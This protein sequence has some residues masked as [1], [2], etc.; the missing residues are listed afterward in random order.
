AHLQNAIIFAGTMRLFAQTCEAVAATTKKK[1]KV[2][3]VAEYIRTAP[4]EEAAC[5]AVFLTGFAFPRNRNSN[6]SVGGSLLWD[7][8]AR[9][10]GATWDQ[11]QAAYRRHGDLG[12]AAA[13]L[14]T[15]RRHTND[16]AVCAVSV[17]FE[18]IAAR[19]GPDHKGAA[20]AELLQHM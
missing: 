20:V 7:A 14:F 16:L 17:R 3:L 11:M 10:T 1:E 6:L 12:S 18:E 13:E 19:R 8:V 5:A 2:R 4:V 15:E 9:V